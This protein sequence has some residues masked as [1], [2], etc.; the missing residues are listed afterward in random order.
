R[1]GR[2]SGDTS[3]APGETTT[4]EARLLYPGMFMYHCATGDVPNHIVMACT[5]ESWS[6]TFDTVGEF[7]YFCI[8]HP[9]MRAMVIVEA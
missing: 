5:V 1:T 4:I 7:E 2:R 8:P 3:V 9:W 6:H